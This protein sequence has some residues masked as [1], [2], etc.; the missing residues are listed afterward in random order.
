MT[1]W[2]W[3]VKIYDTSASKWISGLDQDLINEMQVSRGLSETIGFFNFEYDSDTCTIGPEDVFVFS[4]G[5]TGSSVNKWFVGRVDKPVELG[6]TEDRYFSITGREMARILMTE[7][8]VENYY[9]TQQQNV[10][11]NNVSGL[12][13]AFGSSLEWISNEPVHILQHDE[14]QDLVVPEVKSGNWT[15]YYNGVTRTFG[16]SYGWLLDLST[17]PPTGRIKFVDK[18][19]SGS[20]IGIGKYAYI[21]YQTERALPQGRIWGGNKKWEITVSSVFAETELMNVNAH[22]VS[23]LNVLN[24]ACLE[25]SIPYDFWL[26]PHMELHT[27]GRGSGSLHTIDYDEIENLEV[28]PDSSFLL[29]EVL[30]KS[31]SEGVSDYYPEPHDTWTE[32]TGYTYPYWSAG[33]A[34]H[35]IFDCGIKFSNTS[36]EAVEY[37]GRFLDEWDVTPNLSSD[38]ASVVG[39]NSMRVEAGTPVKVMEIWREISPPTPDLSPINLNQNTKMF[40]WGDPANIT[41]MELRTTDVD[42]YTRTFTMNSSWGLTETHLTGSWNRWGNPS[43]TS[44]QKVAWRMYTDT[45]SE[46]VFNVDGLYWGT[47]PLQAEARDTAS[48]QAYGVIKTNGIISYPVVDNTITTYT[49]A[50]QR[51][52]AI[53]NTYKDP[54]YMIDKVFFDDGNLEIMPGDRLKIETAIDGIYYNTTRV[55]SVTHTILGDDL[56]TT[57]ECRASTP[58]GIESYMTQLESEIRS[59]EMREQ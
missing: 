36:S 21:T 1:D 16:S 25:T 43:W 53:L 58:V 17:T 46:F 44:I 3:E 37:G 48:Q 57:V 42:R 23:M 20:T 47:A 4:M 28:Y 49:E 31:K 30:V 10:I 19:I 18:P 22:G 35:G 38:S 7:T 40:E 34:T 9:S 32:Y 54:I 33:A 13:L 6:D 15:L 45:S 24:T 29:N 5:E 2:E 12:L 11:K 26:D 8:Q 52:D 56:E 51:A 55:V 39:G 14:W 27:Q 59:L 50:K 41:Y